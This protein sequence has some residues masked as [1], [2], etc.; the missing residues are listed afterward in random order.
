MTSITIKII[1]LTAI[2]AGTLLIIIS[3]QLEFTSMFF[4]G[5]PYYGTQPLMKSLKGITIP[6]WQASAIGATLLFLLSY[7][8][9]SL[10][11]K[12][13]YYF[14]LALTLF[15]T[16]VFTITFSTDTEFYTNTMESGFALMVLGTLIC[17]HRPIPHK[18]NSELLDSEA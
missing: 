5:N 15:I 2:I 14:I 9:N 12:I 13:S 7:F 18:T 3:S 8:R 17:L 1:K 4:H 16:T 6:V 10:F 11:F